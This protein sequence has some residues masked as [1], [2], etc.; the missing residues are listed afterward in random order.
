M[1]RATNSEY[2]EAVADAQAGDW[3]ESGGDFPPVHDFK[4]ND[5][6]I[7]KFIGTVTKVIKGESRVLHEFEVDGDVVQAWGAAA[8]DSRIAGLEGRIVKVIRTGK[9]ITTKSGRAMNEFLVY[10][11]PA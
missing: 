5:T 3:E 1:P 2:E 8:L 4:E 9:K 7:G 11:K 6:L 10:S